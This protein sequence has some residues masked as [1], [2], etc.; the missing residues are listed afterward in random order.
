MVHYGP[1]P[2]AVFPEHYSLIRGC[3][4]LITIEYED[5]KKR[6]YYVHF[7]VN[8]DKIVMKKLNEYILVYLLL[9]LISFLEDIQCYG[10]NMIISWSK[11]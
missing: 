10:F 4:K 1:N 2:K 8:W 7:C 11:H 9:Y 3:I 5:H 6:T